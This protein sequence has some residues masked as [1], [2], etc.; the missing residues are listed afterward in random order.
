M[1]TTSEPAISANEREAIRLYERGVAAARGGQRRVASGL[2]SRAVQLNP[3]HEQAWLWLSGVLDNP[4]EVAFCLRS[5]LAINPANARA[6]EGLHWLAQRTAPPVAPA[7]EIAPIVVPIAPAAPPAERISEPGPLARR[8]VGRLVDGV[9]AARAEAEEQARYQGE[10]WW[11]NWRR[12][13]SAMGRA[14]LVFWSAPVALLA[15]TL[16]LNG[17]LRTAVER[18][19]QFAQ[20]TV[21]PRPTL[22]AALPSLRATAVPDLLPDQPPQAARDAAV[23][24]YL[25]AIETPREQLRA[26]IA[27]YRN[28]TAR[29]GG[30]SVLH[31]SAARRLR[32]VVIFAHAAAEALIPP[33]ELAIA[34]ETYLTGLALERDA[35]NDMIAFYASYEVP[36]A[37]RAAITMEEAAA[38][39]AAARA[40][41]DARRAN[42]APTGAEARTL[43]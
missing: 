28:D 16:A 8:S 20:V 18:N 39:L 14:R 37:N 30:S 42:L 43:R 12:S 9:R 1:T 36:R 40:A 19:E 29:P 21:V 31:A 34:H 25:S 13:R 35:L 7:V 24:A 10:S 26:A 17:A 11:V 5:V 15:L 4:D 23:L 38:R 3:R 32:E 6:Q 27:N 33:P 22:I 41:F 2:L